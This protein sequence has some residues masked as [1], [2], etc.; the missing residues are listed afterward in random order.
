MGKTSPRKAM[1]NIRAQIDQL[2]AKS[3]EL[4]HGEQRIRLLEEAVRL[5]DESGPLELA[6]RTRIE[7]LEAATFGGRHDIARE[8]FFWCLKRHDED[9]VRFDQNDVLWK[10]KWVMGA[11]AETTEMSREQIES[12]FADMT[13]RFERAGSTLHA[14]HQIRREVLADMGDLTATAEATARLKATKRDWLSDCRACVCDISAA[15]LASLGIDEPALAEAKP[16]L[17]G[18][19]KC[20]HV[21]HRTYARLLLPLVR[22]GRL[23]EAA[24]FDR[25]GLR[26]IGENPE[27]LFAAS[28]HL[29]YAAISGNWEGGVSIAETFGPHALVTPSKLNR[30]HFHGA[31]AIF[32]QMLVEDTPH[33]VGLRMPPRW[34]GLPDEAAIDHGTLMRW[35]EQDARTLAQRFDERNGNGYYMSWLDGLPKLS[36]LRFSVEEDPVGLH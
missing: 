32:L 7:L 25:E 15:H 31:L 21:P 18:R 35:F 28:Q 26:L 24:T 17:I 14:V 27:F 20:T 33:G 4:A 8:A 9:P 16:I 19:L 10:Y 13:M 29:I 1:S 22:L 34:P 11:V 6:F 5:A 36:S 12:M 2:V 23:S 3:N 30:M